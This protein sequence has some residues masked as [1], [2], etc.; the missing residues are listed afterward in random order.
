M[1]CWCGVPSQ[2]LAYLLPALTL[3]LKRAEAAY[4][5]RQAAI[6]ASKSSGS[7]V[8]IKEED[9]WTVQVVDTAVT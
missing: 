1:L 7:R 4:R 6:A 5:R 8:N 2:T 3:A 9:L